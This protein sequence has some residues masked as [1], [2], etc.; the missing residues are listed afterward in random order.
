MAAGARTRDGR[1][2]Y[3]L[4]FRQQA[5]RWRLPLQPLRAPDG[6]RVIFACTTPFIPGYPVD[7]RPLHREGGRLEP[8]N[9]HPYAH[10]RLRLL[11]QFS[12]DGRHIA[13]QREVDAADGTTPRA[14]LFVA[15]ADGRKVHRITPWALRAGDHPDWSPTARASSSP[16]TSKGSRAS[17]A[18]STPSGPTA[19]TSAS[20]PT[21]RAAPRN[22]C[23]PPTP[24]T[25]GG[26]PSPDAGGSGNP[27]IYAMRTDGTA[28]S[29][30]EHSS[31]WDS[32]PDWAPGRQRCSG[33]G[34]S[35]HRR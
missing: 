33:L 17:R 29:V 12:P 5:R 30:I 14:A 26:S 22:G 4:C 34:D 10:P 3:E 13:F 19:P 8:A 31:Y 9:T 21:R 16:P 7:R 11:P 25:G 18:T 35:R 20:S 15:N 23:R 2:G 27:A 1:A 6:T 32:A 24:Q 28:A